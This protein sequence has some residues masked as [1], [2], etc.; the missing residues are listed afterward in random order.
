MAVVD[1]ASGLWQLVSSEGLIGDSDTFFWTALGLS[2]WCGEPVSSWWPLRSC[3][4]YAA[5]R[6][7][8]YRGL[9]TLHMRLSTLY[10][11]SDVYTCS[12]HALRCAVATA[13][14]EAIQT[15]PR[16]STALLDSQPTCTSTTPTTQDSTLLASACSG[17]WLAVGWTLWT[18]STTDTE[19]VP[20]YAP[21][22][23][24]I[25]PTALTLTAR[26]TAPSAKGS[27]SSGLSQKVSE[28]EY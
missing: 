20:T 22:A 16:P 18:D 21:A 8:S 25:T 3:D 13:C 11:S 26:A 17:Q 7:A 24:L 14:Q 1:V 19:S 5:H 23:A 4:S 9:R 15:A 10:L 12:S 28:Y 6:H 27:T 2:C